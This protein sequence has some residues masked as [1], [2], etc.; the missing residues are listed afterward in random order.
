[1][2]AKETP[3]ISTTQI[4]NKTIYSGDIAMRLMMENWRRYLKEAE[5]YD[6][7]PDYDKMPGAGKSV[8][9]FDP[10]TDYD[11]EGLTHGGVSHSIKHYMEF[12]SAAVQQAI[13]KAASMVSKFNNVFIKKAGGD[14][15]VAQD[16]KAKQMIAQQPEMILNTFDMINDK[17][18]NNEPLNDSEK[19]LL[20]LVQA[21]FTNYKQLAEKLLATALDVDGARETSQ[22]VKLLETGKPIKF[23]A[24]YGGEGKVYA[25]NPKDSA[26]VSYMGGKMS[27]F[28]KIDKRGVDKQKVVRYFTKGMEIKNPVV[29]EALQA[30]AGPAAAQPQ[31]QKKKEK[32]QQQQQKKRPGDIV[33]RLKQAGKP[34]EQIKQILSK[35]FPNLPEA[36][37]TNMLANIKI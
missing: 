31:Q 20:P 18:L 19:Q 1:M 27:T 33:R 21:I 24:I 23:T 8:I 36:A 15:P 26:I 4:K 6:Q 25:L 29:L 22:V 35:A 5:F 11:K 9:V 3:R 34:D 32:P 2:R 37:V 28:F 14:D 12:D 17:M 13:Q 10:E 30:W 16:D 7:Q